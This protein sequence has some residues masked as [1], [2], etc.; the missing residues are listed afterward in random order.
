MQFDLEPQSRLEP[1]EVID[2]AKLL[3]RHSIVTQKLWDK[4]FNE[5]SS[6]LE[7]GLISLKNVYSFLKAQRNIGGILEPEALSAMIDYLV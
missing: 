7:Q 6:N 2:L 4:V 5:F 1:D 3:A